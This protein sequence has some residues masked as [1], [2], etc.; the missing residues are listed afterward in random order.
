MPTITLRPTA[1]VT[2]NH[3]RY[4]N[5]SSTSDAA[6]T[7]IDDTVSDEAATTI[8]QAHHSTSV[9]TA[10]STFKLGGENY[11]HKIFIN[12]IT[13]YYDY[14]CN[15][16][17]KYGKMTSVAISTAIYVNGTK[18]DALKNT[19]SDI[20]TNG[21]SGSWKVLNNAFNASNFSILED[22]VYDSISA[23]NLQFDITTE[24]KCGS[25]SVTS[26]QYMYISQV[27]AVIDYT[28]AYNLVAVGNETVNVISPGYVKDGTTVYFEATPAL[29]HKFSGWYSD[30]SCTSLVSS[31]PS[32]SVRVNGADKTLYANGKRIEAINVYYKKN[33]TWSL[34]K[35]IYIKQNNRYVQLTAKE[36]GNALYFSDKSYMN[37]IPQ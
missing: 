24:W 19:I 3:N 27:Y 35:K 17:T 6:Y 8:G 21:D 2:V 23:L 33:G 32:Y 13:I 30:S 31:S 5:G 15:N 14:W 9:K 29:N 4:K 36:F 18:S 1:N 34:V 16:P 22:T 10:T 20:D 28:N 12:S 26:D 25:G 37:Q 11:N 7:L